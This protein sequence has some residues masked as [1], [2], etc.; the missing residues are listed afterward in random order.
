MW[1]GSPLLTRSVASSLR[2]SC[3]V[4]PAVPNSGWWPARSVQRRRSMT[5][6]VAGEMTRRVVPSC[7]WNR[8]GIGFAHPAFVLVIAPDEGD[9]P[10]ALGVAAD[11]RRDDGEPLRRTP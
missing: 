2:K 4:K 9:Y 7:R 1:I 6:T 3:G 5:W 10:F 11:D 8:N